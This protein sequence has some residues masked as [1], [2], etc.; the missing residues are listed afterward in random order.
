[1]DYHYLWFA[2]L[3]ITSILYCLCYPFTYLLL[4]YSQLS[5]HEP[6][7]QQCCLHWEDCDPN[8][9]RLDVGCYEALFWATT[10]QGSPT[11]SVPSPRKMNRAIS[12]HYVTLCATSLCQFITST[13]PIYHTPSRRRITTDRHA[14]LMHTCMDTRTHT[15]THVHTLRVSSYA[16]H[17]VKGE[18]KDTMALS[19]GSWTEKTSAKL[20]DGFE[21]CSVRHA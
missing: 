21:I 15:H 19:G 7:K 2:S 18:S 8:G 1:M 4:C 13:C 3:Y 17:S 11:S 12:S 6:Q 16:W 10:K 5:P 20:R 9:R 14:L